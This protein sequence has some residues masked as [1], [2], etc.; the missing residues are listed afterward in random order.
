MEAG[1]EGLSD[2]FVSDVLFLRDKLLN[3]TPVKQVWTRSGKPNAWPLEEKDE[4]GRKTGKTTAT[5]VNGSK[6]GKTL[7][8]LLAEYV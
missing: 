1:I 4:N 3:E 8:F 5:D 6:T 7:A 2:E